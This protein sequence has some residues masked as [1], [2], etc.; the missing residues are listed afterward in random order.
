MRAFFKG[1]LLAASSALIIACGGG[2][3]MDKF[4]G[5]LDQIASVIEANKTDADKAADAVEKYIKDNEAE[6]KAASKAFADEA[7]A[8]MSKAMENP[9]KAEEI[10]KEFMEKNKGL[11]EKMEA[12]EKRM[13]KLQEENPALKDN[14]R[15][16]AAMESVMKDALGGMM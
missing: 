11:T 16:K 3:P 6:I 8:L 9:E 7:K 1:A 2:S 4:A 13:E 14:A 10:Q 12:L 15:I 5:H